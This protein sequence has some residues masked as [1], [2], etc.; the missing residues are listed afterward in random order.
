MATSR[1]CRATRA[2]TRSR[3]VPHPWEREVEAGEPEVGEPAER[4]PSIVNLADAPSEHEGRV[5][6]L[7][8]GAGSDLTGLNW[9]S[10]DA[11]EVGAPPHCHSAE[12][13]IFVVLAGEGIVTAGDEQWTAS[14]G[15]IA[16]APPVSGVTRPSGE[17][18]PVDAEGALRMILLG[19][20]GTTAL[21]L[22]SR[23]DRFRFAIPA[24]DLLRQKGAC[25]FGGEIEIRKDHCNMDRCVRARQ[26]QPQRHNMA[27]MDD[28][29]H[30]SAQHGRGD[31]IRMSLCFN[32]QLQYFFA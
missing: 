3:T 19:P 2:G 5:R 4:P 14:A 1:T 23:G 11:G 22:W 21:D 8:E 29:C 13:E 31:V 12:E 28:R 10:L 24:L 9:V 32:G 20:G 16:I 27:V 17:G 7:A 26:R 18:P 6:Y 25:L 30:Q 15:A